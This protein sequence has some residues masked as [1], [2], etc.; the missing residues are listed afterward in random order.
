MDYTKGPN[1]YYTEGHK[2][3]THHYYSKS[4]PFPDELIDNFDVNHFQF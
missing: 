3:Q 1:P 4:I 2:Q